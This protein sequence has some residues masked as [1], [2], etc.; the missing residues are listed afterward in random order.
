MHYQKAAE[1]PTNMSGEYQ[2]FY[3]KCCLETDNDYGATLAAL[4]NAIESY[5][6]PDAYLARAE[7]YL[8]NGAKKKKKEL[9]FSEKPAEALADLQIVPDHDPQHILVKQLSKGST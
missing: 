4:T 1:L 5:P 9:I 6:S 7:F 8:N 3:A 2:L